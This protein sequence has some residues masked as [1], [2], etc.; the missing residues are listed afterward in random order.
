[1][2]D[3]NCPRCGYTTGRKSHILRHI[4]RKIPCQGIIE[5]IE[6]GNLGN[7]IIK[8]AKKK[9]KIHRQN[10]KKKKD[11]IKENKE[12]KEENERLRNQTI[13]TQN[14]QT[15]NNNTH[16][17]TQNITINITPWRDP[18]CEYLK[19]KDYVHCINRMIM[20]VPTLIKKIH[21]NPE[22][23]ENHNIY[24]SNIRNNLAMSY[25]GKKWNTCNQ[26]KLIKNLI[27]DNEYI[28][29]EWLENGED[30]F[31]KEMEKFEKYIIHKEDDT[32]IDDIKEEIKLLLYN[33]RTMVKN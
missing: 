10:Q 31:P 26:D 22:H 1:M 29:E 13:Q 16:N 5:D 21:F 30:K 27:K 2:P 11:L 24:I 17:N 32:V 25:D 20:S 7:V 14:I 3:Y 23:P 4:N 18:N 28:L 9:A 12:L 19:D 33:N 8:K 15:Q 6:V